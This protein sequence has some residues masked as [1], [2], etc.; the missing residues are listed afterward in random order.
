LDPSNLII[1]CR[2]CGQL[3]LLYIPH[4]LEAKELNCSPEEIVKAGKLDDEE[5]KTGT[6][7]HLKNVAKTI[8]AKFIDMS[9][10]EMLQCDCGATF[11]LLADYY[12]EGRVIV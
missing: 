8:G 2:K 5:K 3:Y 9:V 10:K 7:E 6:I 12:R 1:S 11:D 4:K